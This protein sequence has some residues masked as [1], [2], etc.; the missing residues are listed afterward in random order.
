MNVSGKKRTL[1]ETIEDELLGETTITG[2][3]ND[4]DDDDNDES[5]IK[6]RNCSQTRVAE[7]NDEVN[8]VDVRSF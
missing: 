3:T 4:N 2:A 1:S 8:I 7:E 5:E 6:Q